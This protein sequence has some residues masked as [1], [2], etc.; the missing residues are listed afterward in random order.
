VVCPRSTLESLVT[1]KMN[2]H[3]QMPVSYMATPNQIEDERSEL[4]GMLTRHLGAKTFIVVNAFFQVVP[5]T[6]EGHTGVLPDYSFSVNRNTQSG[7]SQAQATNQTQTSPVLPLIRQHHLGADIYHPLRSHRSSSSIASHDS[8]FS[9]YSDLSS[10]STTYEGSI[11]GSISSGF[12]GDI[13]SG[14]GIAPNYGPGLSRPASLSIDP[15]LFQPKIQFGGEGDLPVEDVEEEG[16]EGEGQKTAVPRLPRSPAV[17]AGKKGKSVISPTDRKK[18]S[19]AR[20]VS[21]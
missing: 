20:K 2:G 19:H 16:D 21:L 1:V 9:G 17:R 12:S 6:P 10:W 8:H 5:P 14:M 18:V 3:W 7:L 15:K 4:S 13:D 11:N